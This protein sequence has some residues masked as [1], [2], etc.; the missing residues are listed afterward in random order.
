ML[1]IGKALHAGKNPV[2]RSVGLLALA[3]VAA[4]G[5]VW[6]GGGGGGPERHGDNPNHEK[7]SMSGE[8]ATDCTNFSINSSAVVSA[9]CNTSI[10]SNVD[11]SSTSIDLGQHLK[12]WNGGIYWSNAGIFN[13]IDDLW[14][15]T[16]CQDLQIDYADGD[17]RIGGSCL[18]QGS[19][20]WAQTFMRFGLRNNNGSLALK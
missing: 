3:A 1:D 16:N 17:V 5:T 7:G 19:H 10:D 13:D 20:Q 11:P 18:T 14:V 12:I 8:V 15:A 4:A 2:R 6:A 9:E